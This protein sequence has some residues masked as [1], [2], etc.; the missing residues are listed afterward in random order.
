KLP[1]KKFALLL[2]YCGTGYTGMQI[3]RSVR[4]IEYELHRA[5]AL[6]GVIGFMRAART[7][8]GVHAAGQVVSLKIMELDNLVERINKHLPAQIRIWGYV[9]TQNSFNCKTSCDSRVYEYLLPTYVLQPPNPRY[10]PNSRIANLAGVVLTEEEKAAAGEF[11]VLPPATRDDVNNLR[12][13]RASAEV[14]D[15]LREALGMYLGSKNYH[16]FTIR[17]AF[18]DR[19]A[20]RKIMWFKCGEPFIRDDIEWVSCKV[21]G[22]SFMMHQIRKMIGLAIMM[23]RTKTPPSL[24]PLAWGATKLNIPKAPG[25]GLLLERTVYKVYNEKNLD[26]PIEFE[27]YESTIEEF[28]KEW[29]YSKM[30]EE[31]TKNAVFAKWARCIDERSPDYAWFLNGDGQ[32]HEEQRPEYL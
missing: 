11:N 3:N 28:K 9:R 19:S 1:K 14:L 2:G 15:A 17:K 12:A 27:P 10:Y 18:T 23:I 24:I 26:K 31:E 8:K 13:Y 7:D 20:I 4:T 16:N 29:I 21:F 25:V 22:Q 6:S 32:I 30:I 5:F